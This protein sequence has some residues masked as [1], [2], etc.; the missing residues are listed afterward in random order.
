VPSYFAFDVLMAPHHGS[1]K[2]N[3]DNLAK[4]AGP[5]LVISCQGPPHGAGGA[6]KPYAKRGARF[7]TT[8]TS[9]AITV[10]S[11]RSGLVVETFLT[12]ERI[13]LHSK[14]REE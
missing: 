13:A 14:G 12:G 9:G 7:L 11:H 10:R 8:W 5:Q 6:D 1:A 3:T 2:A 4:W